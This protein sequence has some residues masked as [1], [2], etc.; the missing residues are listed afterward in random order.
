MT[1]ID[2]FLRYVTYDTQSDEHSDANPLHRQAERCWAQPWPRSWPRWGCTRHM[3][4]YGYVYAWLPATAGARESRAWAL[5]PHGHLPRRAGGGGEAP[6]CPL[7]GGDLVLN[8]EKGIVT[9]LKDFPDLAGQVGKDL[10]VTDGTTLLGADDKAGIAEI[11]TAMEHLLAH[12]E[13]P[14]GRVAVCFTPDE[15]V[16]CGTKCFDLKPS[17]RISPTRWTAT[18]WARSAMKTSTP[19]PRW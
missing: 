9:S 18:T 10:V 5:S 3:D 6:R 1:A 19:P 2:R 17:A 11:L 14:H 12:P 8:Q 7:R 15:E 13:R 16:G 4:E